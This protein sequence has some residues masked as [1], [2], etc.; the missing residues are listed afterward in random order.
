MRFLAKKMRRLVKEWH[1]VW[2]TTAR[3][4]RST[5]SPAC[6][7]GLGRGWHAR[8][9]LAACPHPS[10]PPQAGEG[11]HRVR[12][13][14]DRVRGSDIAQQRSRR[15]D[16]IDHGGFVGLRR[17]ADGGGAGGGE[18]LRDLARETK[19]HRRERALENAGAR[20]AVEIGLRAAARKIQDA[21]ERALR[22][23]RRNVRR[24][25]LDLDRAIS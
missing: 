9:S 17:E 13:G 25:A 4:T 15:P 12:G 20:G 22:Q 8:M 16:E 19:L 11:T 3:R 10:P 24:E 21:V 5:P 2:P 18:R 1:G 7:G 14:A 6:G 23:R